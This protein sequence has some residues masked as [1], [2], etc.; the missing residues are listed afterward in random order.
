M[1]TSP[2]PGLLD[3][4]VERWHTYWRSDVARLVRDSDL[5]WLRRWIEASDE[6]ARVRVVLT[7]ARLVHGSTGQPVLNPL[8]AYAQQLTQE[9]ERAETQFGMTPDARLRLLAEAG[10]GDGV[11]DEFARLTAQLSTPL[12]DAEN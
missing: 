7:G 10:V 9:V 4:S 3:E 8:A 12:D 11:D 5:P 1:D 2:P 6:L